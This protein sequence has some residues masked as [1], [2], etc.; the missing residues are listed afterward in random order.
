MITVHHESWGIASGILFEET[1][2]NIQVSS[3]VDKNRLWGGHVKMITLLDP[4]K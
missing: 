4:Q 3:F 2:Q 1:R